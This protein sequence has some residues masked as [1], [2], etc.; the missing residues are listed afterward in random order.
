LAGWFKHWMITD[1]TSDGPD[2]RG[3]KPINS[4]HFSFVLQWTITITI[5]TPCYCMSY[6]YSSYCSYYCVFFE[7]DACSHSKCRACP[8][9]A[10]ATPLSICLYQVLLARPSF[11]YHAT[12]QTRS[13]AQ[14]RVG[15]LVALDGVTSDH[16]AYSVLRRFLFV[17]AYFRTSS[18]PRLSRRDIKRYLVNC[19]VH[20]RGCRSASSSPFGEANLLAQRLV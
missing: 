5:T 20:F 15:D 16:S 14:L 2:A 12:P 3:W 4:Y 6:A 18:S 19:S 17:S 7:P 9:S 11:R 1:H 13:C 10:N 8:H